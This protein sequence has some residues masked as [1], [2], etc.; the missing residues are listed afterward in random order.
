VHAG[1]RDLHSSPTRRSSDLLTLA[2][3][4]QL[5]R[6]VQQR[7][8]ARQAAAFLAAQAACP[9]CGRERSIKDHKTVGLRTLFGKV[10]LESPRLRRSEEH[11]S[12][13]QSPDH[14]VCRL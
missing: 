12:E 2:E 6:E 4:K 14:L 1:D 7:V 9:G 8:L 13:L 10:T 11:T 3:G 5:L